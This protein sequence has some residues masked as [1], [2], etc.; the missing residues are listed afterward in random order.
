MGFDGGI[1]VSKSLRFLL[2]ASGWVV[3]GLL[4]SES[5]GAVQGLAVQGVQGQVASEVSWGSANG[6]VENAQTNDFGVL[7]PMSVART[8]GVFAA[9]PASS[10]SIDSSGDRVWV[11][12]VTSNAAL[13]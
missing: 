11:G 8:V 12:C 1:V 6:C 13:A 3:F 7:V 2:L 5:A 9:S 4:V 10:A